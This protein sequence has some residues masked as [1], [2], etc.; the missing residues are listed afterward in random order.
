M[1][2][3]KLLLQM[4]C[5]SFPLVF[6]CMLGAFTIMLISFWLEDYLRQTDAA[7][8]ARLLPLPSVIYTALV[9]VMNLYYRKL[10]TYLTEWGKVYI[11]YSFN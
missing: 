2:Q 11:V 3:L 5:A 9:H 8:S 4:Y 6:L 10:A 7:W 1:F